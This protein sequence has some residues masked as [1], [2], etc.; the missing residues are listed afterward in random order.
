M[1]E[2]HAFSPPLGRQIQGA[3]SS[4]LEGKVPRR[5]MEVIDGHA[6]YLSDLSLMRN[7]SQ[8]RVKTAI[9]LEASKRGRSAAKSPKTDKRN[10]EH[11][12]E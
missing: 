12:V 7:N 1:R 11:P 4:P 10:A 6:S 9:P 8:K 2:D 3:K 5:P